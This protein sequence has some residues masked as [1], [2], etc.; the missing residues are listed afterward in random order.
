MDRALALGEADAAKFRTGLRALDR[1]DAVLPD[2]ALEMAILFRWLPEG[3]NLRRAAGLDDGGKAGGLHLEQL[4]GKRSMARKKRPPEDYGKEDQTT[5]AA[6]LPW[7]G[8]LVLS[9]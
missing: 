7:R 5:V 6:F 9:P 3:V 8:S 2:L 4:H 1:E